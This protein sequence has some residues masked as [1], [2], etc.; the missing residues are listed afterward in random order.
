[1]A[2]GYEKINAIKSKLK[3]KQTVNGLA[4]LMNCGPRTIFRH[5]EVINEENCGLRKFKENGETYYIIQ[6]EKEAN[7][8]Q[9][10]VKQLEKIKKNL[11]ETSAADIKTNK[12]LDKLIKVMQTTN[13]EEFKPDAITTD[14]DYVLDYGPFSDDKL[15][16]THVN[17]VLKAIHE[18]FAI[19]IQYSHATDHSAVV[20]E[21]KEVN[22]V[23]VIMRMDTLYLIAG[24][25]DDKG[26]QVF[27]NYLFE[28]IKNVQETN[29]AV[30]KFV[31]DAATHYKYA[32]GK[33]TGKDKPEDI[34]LEIRNRWLQTQF[35]RSHFNPEISKRYDKN[36]NMIVDM[37]LR[38]TPDFV[39]WLMG[40]ATDV[41]I[42]KPASL[43]ESVK[44]KLKDA[45]SELDR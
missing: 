36:K 14:P 43:K 24:E 28:Q 12:L 5:L 9:D 20:D 8:N 18:G 3:V 19:K 11:S 35:E 17:K 44:Q 38:I 32:F 26:N 33:Y 27:K 31:F 7:F 21:N 23:K 39:S 41:R 29:H 15:N 2:T 10:V 16:S 34:T 22:P 4:R 30:P 42:L 37:K 25:E 13:P 45:L 1:M 6:T 40:V